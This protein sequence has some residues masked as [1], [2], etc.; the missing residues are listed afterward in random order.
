MTATIT[1]PA[2]TRSR[3]FRTFWLG[4]TVSQFGDR[5]SELALPLIAVT[6]LGAGATGLGVLTAA[7]WAPNL[8]AVVVGAWVDQRPVKRR[9]MIV[10][11]LLRAVALA[12]V[13]IGYA[14]GVLTL[15]QLITVGLLT[16]VGQVLF[17]MAYQTFYVSLVP[18]ESYVDANSKLSATRGVSFVAGPAAA[19]GLVQLVTAPLAVLT[20]ALSFVVSAVLLGRIRTAEPP[21]APAGPSTLRLALDGLRLVLHKPMLR[22]CLGCTT[23]V[24][25]FT[26]IGNALLVL[27]ASREL[28]LSAGAIGLGF[29]IGAVGSVL[30]AVLAGPASRLLGVGWAASVGAAVFPLP[31]AALALAG[32]STWQKVAWLAG[33]EFVSGVGVML[34]DI[35]LNALLTRATPEGARGRRAGAYAAV[36]YGSRPVGALV[37]GVL[38]TVLGLP[39]SLVVA[40]VG[41]AL[42][43]IWLLA[44]PIRRVRT[45]D[46]VSSVDGDYTEAASASSS[47][48]EM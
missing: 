44:S 20:D 45:L 12:S 43:A 48:P 23:T 46:E 2:A 13:P 29:G 47:R 11:D 28:G 35:N 1:A 18:P 17:T 34:M 41:G 6:L 37:G 42:G 33:L 9:L 27:F 16:G 31:Y 25:F 24:N 8:L 22:S 14:F 26:F 21:P 38:G 5:I 4:E 3:G 7:I 32:G 36:N 10:A 30:G 39:I 15:A 19:G 40:G